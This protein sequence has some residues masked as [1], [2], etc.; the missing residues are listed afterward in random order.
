MV[1][2]EAPQGKAKAKADSKK[3]PIPK[4]KAESATS[5]RR[6]GVKIYARFYSGLKAAQVEIVFYGVFKPQCQC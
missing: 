1:S 2:L 4:T 3:K 5:R 6:K